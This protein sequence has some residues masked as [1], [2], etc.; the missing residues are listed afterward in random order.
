MFFYYKV[1]KNK[2]CLHCWFLICMKYGIVCKVNAKLVNWLYKKPLHFTLAFIKLYS[3]ILL[4]TKNI[5]LLSSL[6]GLLIFSGALNTQSYFA[7]KQNT[8][9]FYFH[10]HE[11]F[12]AKTK[13]AFAAL[14]SSSS[15]LIINVSKKVC[16]GYLVKNVI[17]LSRIRM[18]FILSVR[19]H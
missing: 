2:I 5:F 16:P 19:L 17:T 12:N 1:W 15:K 9:T 10:K 3:Y 8:I 13:Y 6:Q 11:R 4:T 7:K 18:T 14:R